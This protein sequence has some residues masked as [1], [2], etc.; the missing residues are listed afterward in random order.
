MFIS[1]KTV[2][3]GWFKVIYKSHFSETSNLLFQV[4]KTLLTEGLFIPLMF[5]LQNCP[6][7]I[8]NFTLRNKTLHLNQPQIM[9][10]WITCWSF[11]LID[12]GE[13]N[14]NFENFLNTLW[15]TFGPR[16]SGLKGEWLDPPLLSNFVD[17][18]LFNSNWLLIVLDS[19]I[20]QFPTGWGRNGW[21]KQPRFMFIDLSR[22]RWWQGL[23][24]M[25]G[26]KSNK[27]ALVG[28]C[29]S[30]VVIIT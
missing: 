16:T 26:V 28:V 12:F 10:L 13:V 5:Q 8:A 30:T 4:I 24:Y 6:L 25:K 27:C 22:W 9:F 29:L 3:V 15:Q 11:S 20:K 17:V 7:M 19:P 2:W 18:Y 23:K 21:K 1:F 14:T